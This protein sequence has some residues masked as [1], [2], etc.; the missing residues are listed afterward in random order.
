[1]ISGFR[2][3]VDEICGLLGYYAPLTGTSVP[4][5]W[6]S[7]SVPFS[8]VKKSK[9]ISPF[10]KDKEVQEECFL[11]FLTP[12]GT[13]RFSRNVGNGLPFYGV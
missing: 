13:D 11:D 7:L 2:R 1:V 12:D 5:F 6:D 9:K 8:R 10:F 3:N 4:T